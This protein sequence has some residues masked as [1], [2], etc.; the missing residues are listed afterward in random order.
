M[1]RVTESYQSDSVKGRAKL[2]AA[3]S[4]KCAEEGALRATVTFHQHERGFVHLSRVVSS[5]SCNL[6][7]HNW[8]T[9][10]A[11]GSSSPRTPCGYF[12]PYHLL[13][14][15]IFLVHIVGHDESLYHRQ[16]VSLRRTFG[17][18]DHARIVFVTILHGY[19]ADTCFMF[20][21]STAVCTTAP[22]ASFVRSHEL[23]F[24][25]LETT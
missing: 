1:S 14:A 15:R 22:R 21:G 16:T 5:R 18:I 10:P 24:P 3:T 17:Q 2:F 4:V 7:H 20:T 11:C 13:R 23:H 8:L 12:P 9:L 6:L 25:S 19:Y